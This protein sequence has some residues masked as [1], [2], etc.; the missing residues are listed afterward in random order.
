MYAFG[1]NAATVAAFADAGRVCRV[2]VAHDLDA[3]N[4]ALLQ[5]GQ[6]SAVLHHDL[7]L[8][9]RRAC[10]VVMQVHAALSGTPRSWHSG[11]QVV[12]PYNLP[13]EALLSAGALSAS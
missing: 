10:H 9:M 7:A 12:T 1:G 4:L 3:E 5:H 11:V 13:A 2:F 8:D 6:L